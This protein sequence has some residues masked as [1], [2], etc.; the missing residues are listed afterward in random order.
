MNEL[1]YK[2]STTLSKET[3]LP[4]NINDFQLMFHNPE[5][6]K[7]KKTELFKKRIAGLTSY[8]KYQDPNIFPELLPINKIAVPLSVYQLNHYERYRN[9]EI[10]KDKNARKKGKE[11]TF[12]PSY[13]LKSRLASTFVY[14][15]EIGTPY[16]DKNF[17]VYK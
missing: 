11:E 5:L 2:V 4:T 15:E 9:Q 16:D 10:Q 7:L 6:N 3:C 12:Q 13:R 1:G 8:F 17:Y 14:P